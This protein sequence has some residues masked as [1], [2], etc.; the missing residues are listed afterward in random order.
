M[1]GP[2][3]PLTLLL[4]RHGQSEWNATRRLQGQTP[5]V[6]LTEI[7][8]AQALDA[9]RALAAR[10]PGALVSSDLLRATQTAEHCARLLGLTY[11][12][13][14][15]LREQSYGVLE[16]LESGVAEHA[17]WRDPTWAAEGGE[18][19]TQLHRR[20]RTYLHELY[21]DP[22]ADTVALVTHGDTIRAAQA[23]AQGAGPEGMPLV[24][25]DNGSITVL[26]LRRSSGA[27][28]DSGRS[29]AA[30]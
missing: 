6:P 8:H 22:P 2:A 9:A 1:S 30:G 20:V 4:V 14:P 7:G 24:T 27:R 11:S 15:A 5:H 10:R 13:T 26:I 21:A 18:S 23:V 3:R 28:R 16:G 25:P 12:T 17:R 29:R 19:L